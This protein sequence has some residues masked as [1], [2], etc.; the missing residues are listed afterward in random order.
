VGE[1]NTYL[2]ILRDFI[3][4]VAILL[5]V[6]SALWK[7]YRKKDKKL[8]EIR[9][10]LFREINEKLDEILYLLKRLDE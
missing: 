7:E 10:K 9:E 8:E 6:L 2:K 5:V 3:L 1:L 4:P